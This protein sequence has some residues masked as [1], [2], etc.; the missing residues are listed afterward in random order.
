MFLGQRRWFFGSMSFGYHVVL[1]PCVLGVAWYC[2]HGLHVM[3]LIKGL[4]N[5]IVNGPRGK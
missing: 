3:K 2:V 1:C 5:P 4:V